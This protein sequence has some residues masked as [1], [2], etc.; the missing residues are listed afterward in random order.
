M[1]RSSG[2]LY[3][4]R[5]P[6]QNLVSTSLLPHRR[7]MPCSFILLNLIGRELFGENINNEVFIIR[8]SLFSYQSSF[9]GPNIFF[10]ALFANISANVGARPNPEKIPMATCSPCRTV[11]LFITE[12]RGSVKGPVFTPTQNNMGNNNEHAGL[13][14]PSSRVQ[15]RPKPLDFSD[16]KILSMPSFEGEVK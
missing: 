3:C 14:F 15:T 16:G 13:W 6:H 12:R 5:F 7:H 11:E 2:G 9:S 4:F 1:P 8:F 10:S